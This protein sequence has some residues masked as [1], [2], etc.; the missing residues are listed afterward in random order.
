MVAHH[1]CPDGSGYPRG[2]TGNEIP[3][4]AS[5]LRVADVF[6]ALTDARPYKS[7]M[8]PEEALRIMMSFDRGSIHQPSLQILARMVRTGRLGRTG[9][10][11]AR[12]ALPKVAPLLS[13]GIV[14]GPLAH[15]A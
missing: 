4:E 3:I 1:E 9:P 2:L 15:R 13:S 11:V 8:A 14:R 10:A 6:S 5:I 7:A 12:S